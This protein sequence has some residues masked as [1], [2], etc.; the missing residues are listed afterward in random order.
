MIL[1]FTYHPDTAGAADFPASGAGALVGSWIAFKFI[2]HRRGL[3][4]SEAS[5]QSEE[6]VGELHL[7][8]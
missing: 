8:G 1:G 3:G 4:S 5:H 6:D 7:N 2:V